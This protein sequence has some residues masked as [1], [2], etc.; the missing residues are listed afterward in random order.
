MK[1][2]LETMNFKLGTNAGRSRVGGERGKKNAFS[3]VTMNE[4]A[5][6]KQI[7]T[8]THTHTKNHSLPE[9]IIQATSTSTSAEAQAASNTEEVRKQDNRDA[10]GF[11]SN[12]TDF[13]HPSA[14][15]ENCNQTQ[16]DR[17]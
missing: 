5:N 17:G 13:F 15:K 1:I 6:N 7:N 11:Q 4:N 14:H 9:M 12:A 8:H 3:A 16:S 2:L 10:H